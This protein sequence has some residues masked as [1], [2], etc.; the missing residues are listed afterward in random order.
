MPADCPVQNAHYSDRLL[1]Y[2]YF[3]TTLYLIPSYV[4]RP[5]VI[6]HK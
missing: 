4:A 3:A 2:F 1:D 5:L 6:R